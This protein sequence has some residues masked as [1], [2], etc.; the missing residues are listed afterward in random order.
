MKGDLALDS[1]DSLLRWA[2]RISGWWCM[3]G[4]NEG[5]MEISG[6]DDG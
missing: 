5:E 1:S 4:K 3:M 2:Q 6:R